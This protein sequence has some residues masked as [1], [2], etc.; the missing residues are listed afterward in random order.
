MGCNKH[1]VKISIASAIHLNRSIRTCIKPTKQSSDDWLKTSKNVQ[2]AKQQK[3]RY[4]MYNNV[5]LQENFEFN[6]ARVIALFTS[7]CT[8]PI[9][10]TTAV[11]EK[12]PGN[13]RKQTCKYST[14]INSCSQQQVPHTSRKKFFSFI[15]LTNR[16]V[17]TT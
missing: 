14:E 2:S 8:R 3:L 9:L 12:S 7:T 17:R 5:Q 16:T 4:E 10:L 11:D 1:F 6:P 13:D 15:F